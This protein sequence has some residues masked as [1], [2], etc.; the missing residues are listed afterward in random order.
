M[1]ICYEGDNG[2]TKAYGKL[3]QLL[4]PVIKGAEQKAVLVLLNAHEELQK[5]YQPAYE[6]KT[7]GKKIHDACQPASHSEAMRT[8]YA[9]I[10][11]QTK[12]ALRITLRSTAERLSAQK[13]Q[14]AG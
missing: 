10:Q 14:C 7:A 6:K 9:A 5:I 4:D 2:N 12:N 3:F 8:E 1:K 11:A 13:I